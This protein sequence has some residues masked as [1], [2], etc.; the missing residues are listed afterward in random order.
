MGI[1]LKYLAS[2]CNSLARLSLVIDTLV[3]L[4]SLGIPEFTASWYCYLLGPLECPPR[5]PVLS[6]FSPGELSFPSI[7]IP[8]T[9]FH[10]RPLPR[11]PTFA[12]THHLTCPPSRMPAASHMPAASCMPAASPGCLIVGSNIC[13][14]HVSW[15]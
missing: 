10:T 5:P 15:H 9:H 4:C 6:V 12:H 8:D 3:P 7:P 14:T 11:L 1:F 2:S 13:H